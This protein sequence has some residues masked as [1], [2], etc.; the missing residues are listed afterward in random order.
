MNADTL[1]TISVLLSAVAVL[2]S[3]STIAVFVLQFFRSR[4]S[5]HQSKQLGQ[6]L[7]TLSLKEQRRNPITDEDV[8][9][10]MKDLSIAEYAT[11][12]EDRRLIVQE[13]LSATAR[14]RQRP[15]AVGI[16]STQAR[17]FRPP[18]SQAPPP[19]D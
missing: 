9:R 3:A 18:P 6:T 11:S 12:P 8:E 16:T 2:A 17:T 14:Q 7:A 4:E 1:N 10:I 13:L 19:M 15:Q 5:K